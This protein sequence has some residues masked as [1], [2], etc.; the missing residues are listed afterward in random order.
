MG[1]KREYTSR[2]RFTNFNQRDRLS[3]K[4]NKRSLFY[5]I[6]CLAFE[7]IVFN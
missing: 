4:E 2:N 6:S 1:L 7:I 5:N 3:L